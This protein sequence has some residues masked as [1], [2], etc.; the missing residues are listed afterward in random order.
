MFTGGTV[1]FTA[2]QIL[3]DN[4]VGEIHAASGGDWGGTKVDENFV[5]FLK[6]ILGEEFVIRYSKECPQQWYEFLLKFENAKRTVT[7]SKGFNIEISFSFA[8]QFDEWQ[9]QSLNR[10][11]EESESKGVS[12]SNG[13]LVFTAEVVQKIFSP[14]VDKII[15]HITELEK[16]SELKDV[17]F[18]YLFL[19]GGFGASPFLQQAMRDHYKDK[20]VLIPVEAQTA[21]IKGAIHYGHNP[22]IIEKRKSQLTYGL[23]TMT[24]YKKGVH[25]SEK[26]CTYGGKA[27]CQ[28]I[29]LPFIQKG[30]DIELNTSGK[31]I[32][33]PASTF[34][35]STDISFHSL[36]RKVK[37][38][39]VLYL[40]SE[41]V[42]QIATIQVS[43]HDGNDSE[44]EIMF[45]DTEITAKTT[46]TKS[47]KMSTVSIN[48]MHD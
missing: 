40:D 13:Y 26:K 37:T 44:L 33:S 5:Q 6:E 43:L 12:V 35:T 2:H 15:L 47:G 11:I 46:D 10:K 27:Y 3:A 38:N 45:G 18:N 20:P 36:N 19:V 42:K 22:S 31:T 24:E 16:S 48:F 34:A 23:C 32:V 4:K 8:N 1:D 9:N 29:F 28:D 30:E 7:S 41:G 21:V 39:E 25:R 14:V 17:R